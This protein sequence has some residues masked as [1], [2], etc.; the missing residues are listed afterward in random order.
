MQK[1]AMSE[2]NKLKAEIASTSLLEEHISSK[3]DE[4][5]KELAEIKKVINIIN[6]KI[7]DEKLPAI[8]PPEQETIKETMII[9]VVP[10]VTEIEENKKI[11]KIKKKEDVVVI[12]EKKIIPPLIK[13]R[14]KKIK[15]KRKTASEKKENDLILQKENEI[16]NL[17]NNKIEEKIPKII[18]INKNT[19]KYFNDIEEDN[20]F[21]EKK[22]NDK[23][24]D[25]EKKIDYLY[26]GERK[27]DYL[28][29]YETKK[30]KK[31]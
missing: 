15:R 20:L 4:N 21:L 17:Y 27:E 8:P 1:A 2:E 31:N 3:I 14:P 6:P 19:K 7:E 12:D 23:Q 18:K 5:T 30:R 22:I 10:I 25:N 16:D 9:P 24:A 13:N 26:N 11:L 29:K 28:I